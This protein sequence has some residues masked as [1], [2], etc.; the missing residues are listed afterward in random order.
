MGRYAE[1]RS[2]W[3]RQIGL[4]SVLEE[5]NST[6][7]EE[8]DYYAEAHNM[9]TLAR[10]MEPIRGVHIPVLYRPLSGQR[11]LTQEFVTGV[12]I[13]EAGAMRDVGLDV[14]AIGEATLRTA[15]KMLLIDGF[16]H[17]DPHPATCYLVKTAQVAFV[18]ALAATVVLV[19]TFLAQI[20]RRWHQNHRQ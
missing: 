16:F 18:A 3:A 1:Q 15:I 11:V 6:L 20:L 12:K 2:T 19:I 4:R 5:F 14:A 13:S 10:N 8:L 17:A 9:L 7:L